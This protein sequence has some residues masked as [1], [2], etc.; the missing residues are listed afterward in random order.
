MWQASQRH[1]S[2]T[3]EHGLNY[4]ACHT[5][6]DARQKRMRA[7]VQ[8]WIVNY[9]TPWFVLHCETLIWEKLGLA[10][11]VALESKVFDRLCHTRQSFRAFL[12]IPFR[13]RRPVR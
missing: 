4:Q 7:W 3:K 13:V 10:R 6:S 12:L 5:R 11:V 2:L 9:P 8:R 1:F